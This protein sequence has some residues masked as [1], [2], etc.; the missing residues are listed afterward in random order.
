MIRINFLT[1]KSTN[2]VAITNF[3]L[4]ITNALVQCDLTHQFNVNNNFQSV[5]TTVKTF[6]NDTVLLPCNHNCKY[7]RFVLLNCKLCILNQ[8]NLI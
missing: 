7:E 3:I 2:I 1:I 8:N 4:F 6:E 5:P